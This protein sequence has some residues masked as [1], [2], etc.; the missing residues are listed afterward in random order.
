VAGIKDEDLRYVVP[1]PSAAGGTFGLWTKSTLD[2]VKFDFA[3]NGA[4][5]VHIA[6]ARSST[7]VRHTYMKSY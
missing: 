2:I 3:S 1:S 7:C 6:K 4:G 5:F